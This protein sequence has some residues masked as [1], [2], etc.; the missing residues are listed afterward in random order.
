MSTANSRVGLYL[1][2]GNHAILCH[3]IYCK[4]YLGG[5]TKYQLLCDCDIE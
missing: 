1:G 5:T 3:V 2:K 4:N